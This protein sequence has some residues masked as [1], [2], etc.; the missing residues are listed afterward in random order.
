MI[1][2]ERGGEEGGSETKRKDRVPMKRMVLNVACAA[3]HDSSG[4]SA[5]PTAMMSTITPKGRRWCFVSFLMHLL[6]PLPPSPLPLLK[7][8]II[9][10]KEAE[11][12]NWILSRHRIPLPPYISIL[13]TDQR[14]LRCV[15]TCN[16]ATPLV[17][18]PKSEPL[19]I[20][21]RSP[22]CTPRH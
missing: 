8:C 17:V 2:R 18:C 19:Y 4:C 20:Q 16:Q 6:H 15:H 7:L 11:E 1:V 5:S 10:T 9:N 12:N 22:V 14:P 3:L 13:Q 21:S